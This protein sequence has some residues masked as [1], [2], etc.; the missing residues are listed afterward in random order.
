MKETST[1]CLIV[2]ALIVTITFAATITVPGG[3]YGE[4]P[5]FEGFNATF[6]IPVLPVGSSS[7]VSNIFPRGYNG[8]FTAPDGNHTN[9]SKEGTPIFDQRTAFYSFY[10]FNGT[11]LIFA[12]ISLFLFMSILTMP[13]AE[14]DFLL[15]FPSRLVLGLYTLLISVYSMMVAFGSIIDLVF[16]IG[17][18]GREVN[19]LVLVVVTVLSFA[20]Y[21]ISQYRLFRA[22]LSP[23]LRRKIFHKTGIP[24]MPF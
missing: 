2:A 1:A 14:H 13:H 19:G 17:V 3:T 21:V 15:A 18:H 12:A 11:S 24:Q 6:T 16:G 7:N 20:I 4:I 9:M 23:G 8:T 10:Y 5:G 22:L